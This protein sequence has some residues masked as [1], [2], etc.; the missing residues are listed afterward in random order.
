MLLTDGT[1][2]AVLGDETYTVSKGDTVLAPAG[3]K[4]GFTNRTT[5]TARMVAVHPVPEV[6]MQSVD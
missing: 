6:V 3:V 5:T 2:E 4:H 1:L